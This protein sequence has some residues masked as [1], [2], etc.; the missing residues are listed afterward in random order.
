MPGDDAALENRSLGGAAPPC[1][2]PPRLVL[3]WPGLFR[4][5]LPRLSLPGLALLRPGLARASLSLPRPGL[6]GLS[7]AFP[8]SPGPLVP[9]SLVPVSP[10]PALDGLLRHRARDA[11]LQRPW[12]LMGGICPL[13][14]A[15]VG[16]LLLQGG[17]LDVPLLHGPRDVP[18]R[19]VGDPHVVT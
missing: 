9:V 16:D 5:A 13:G 6:P 2:V 7:P 12:S 8:V 14:L 18:E 19:L 11:R 3:P 10:F 1:L 15:Q 17:D 4:L